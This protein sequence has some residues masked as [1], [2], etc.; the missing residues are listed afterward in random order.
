MTKNLKTTPISKRSF[1][2]RLSDN[3][4]K[5]WVLYLMV[6]PVIAY[7]AVFHY[8]PMYGVILAFKDYKIKKGILG[9]PWAG[10]KHFIRFFK[11]YNCKQIIFNT[12]SISLYSIL[13]T[14]PLPIIFALM[15]NYLK[16]KHLQKTVQ[17]LSYVPHFLS[18]VV[19]CGIIN[20]LFKST[21][22][23]N[24]VFEKFGFETVAFLTDPKYFKSLHVW[25][26]AWKDL[27]F[28]AIIYI[29]ALAGVDYQLHEAAILDG[30]SKL[31]R[32]WHIDLASIRPTIM[33]MLILRMGSLMNVGFEK[34]FLL[35]NYLN[36]ASSE[37][38]STYVYQMG[39]IKADYSYSTAIGLFNSIINLILL[40]F[41]NKMS[42]KTTGESLF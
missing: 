29:S 13:V 14:F 12:I 3:I 24:T 4:R 7:F 41:A 20:L 40:L 1:A 33:M 6:I 35:Q 25:S 22:L 21:G 15:L 38:I 30:A 26:D 32:I 42:Q 17:M 2:Y 19:F 28:S 37:V 34:I 39:M 9:S 11:V 36:R 27:G 16:E 31:Q 10:F 18:T 8:A 5:K 23:F